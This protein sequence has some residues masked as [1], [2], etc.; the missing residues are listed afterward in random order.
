MLRTRVNLLKIRQ[1]HQLNTHF[2]TA[3][4]VRPI[5]YPHIDCAGFKPIDMTNNLQ[6]Q[7]NQTIFCKRCCKGH[8]G[9]IRNNL[10]I[11][12]VSFPMDSAS[13]SSSNQIKLPCFCNLN[14]QHTKLQSSCFSSYY[15]NIANTCTYK[16]IADIAN[17]HIHHTCGSFVSTLFSESI[18][19]AWS[20]AHQ[21]LH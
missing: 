11:Q 21:A 15:G 3:Q 10:F 13:A 4:S 1:W 14:I 9:H 17:Y 2:C 5:N 6:V 16:G 18:F 8:I 20:S 7:H 12:I 19:V